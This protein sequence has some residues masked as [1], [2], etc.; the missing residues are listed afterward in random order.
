MTRPWSSRSALSGSGLVIAARKGVILPRR[1]AEYGPSQRR[2][3]CTRS[4]A[5]E[6]RFGCLARVDRHRRY[7][8]GL[9]CPGPGGPSTSRQG[10]E[11]ALRFVEESRG[12]RLDAPRCGRG[13]VGPAGL[14][15]RLLVSSVRWGAVGVGDRLLRPRSEDPRARRSHVP[16]AGDRLRL[17]ARFAR[18]SASSRRA[19]GDRDPSRCR[20]P[21]SRHAAGHHS[22]HQR[23]SRAAGR[24][25]RLLRHP[26]VRRPPAHRDPAA[27]RPVF[28][29]RAQARAALRRRPSRCPSGSGPMDR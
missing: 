9:R 16:G 10:A 2:L 22:W 21:T 5:R 12:T 18:G 7:V 28:T 27:Q 13:L 23:A 25:R 20:P 24:A 29:R 6:A 3:E 14:R 17:R 11:A 19:A 8:H 15:P 4:H 26:W 1:S